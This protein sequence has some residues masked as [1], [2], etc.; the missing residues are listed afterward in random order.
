MGDF[1]QPY[2]TNQVVFS[3]D[4]SETIIAIDEI[5]QRAYQSIPAYPSMT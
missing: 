5:N 4:N 2:F 3:F 1:A